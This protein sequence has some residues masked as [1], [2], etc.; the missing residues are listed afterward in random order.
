MGEPDLVFATSVDEEARA[1]DCAVTPGLLSFRAK[2]DRKFSVVWAG[3]QRDGY[4]CATP[5]EVGYVDICGSKLVFAK[6]NIAKHRGLA[7]P[8]PPKYRA[9]R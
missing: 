2:F 4:N 6:V 1:R 8:F 7:G 3:P 9:S 5:R